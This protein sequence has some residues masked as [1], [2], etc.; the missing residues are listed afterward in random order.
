M[1]LYLKTGFYSVV[2][3][4]PCKDDELLIRAHS[5]DDLDKLQALLKKRC[6]FHGEVLDTPQTDYAYRMIV[7]KETFASFMSRAINDLVYEEYK[8]TK[9]WEAAYR[10]QSNLRRSQ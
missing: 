7:P 10:W 3:K 4:E 8:N 2:A 1:W 5:K 9:S 6:Q